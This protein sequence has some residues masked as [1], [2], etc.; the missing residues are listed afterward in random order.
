MRPRS[1]CRQTVTSPQKPD[2]RSQK[3]GNFRAVAVTLFV[4]ADS[5]SGHPARDGVDAATCRGGQIAKVSFADADH[6]EDEEC[7]RGQEKDKAGREADAEG[8][9]FHACIPPGICPGSHARV[10]HFQCMTSAGTVQLAKSKAVNSAC[11]TAAMTY[12]TG[13]VSRQ[14]EHPEVRRQRP[15]GTFPCPQPGTARLCRAVPDL[16][17]GPEPA[18]GCAG[19]AGEEGQRTVM[20]TA[21]VIASQQWSIPGPHAA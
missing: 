6:D 17:S 12:G 11:R 4:P 15:R 8:I 13:T 14:R 9:R 16:S 1:T 5:Y 3:P 2:T 19:Y 20:T 10:M 21:S 18:R 7:G